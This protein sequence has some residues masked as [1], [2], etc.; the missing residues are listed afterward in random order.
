[1]VSLGTKASLSHSNRIKR[2]IKWP[3]YLYGNFSHIGQVQTLEPLGWLFMLEY[4]GLLFSIF[5]FPLY[6]QSPEKNSQTQM[7]HIHIQHKQENLIKSVQSNL[8]KISSY[9]EKVQSITNKNRIYF[10]KSKILIYF[11]RDLINFEKNS[12]LV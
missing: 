12:N 2:K 4:F 10:L 11:E 5:M 8:I 6:L 9:L 7:D 1:M 3:W